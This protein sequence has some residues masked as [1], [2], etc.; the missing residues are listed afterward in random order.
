MSQIEQTH[1]FP[2]LYTLTG[3]KMIRFWSVKACLDKDGTVYIYKEYGKF[4]GKAIPNKKIINDTKSQT[5]LFQQAIFEAESSWKEMQD[6]KGYVADKKLLT[7]TKTQ[8]MGNVTTPTESSIKESTGKIPLTI[9]TPSQA[10]SLNVPKIGPKIS[11][12]LKPESP[13]LPQKL[14]IDS[15]ANIET[16][17]TISSNYDNEIYK[18]F[19]FLPMLANKFIE[20]KGYVSYP[21]WGQPKLDGVRY[22]ARKISPTEVIL[23]TRNDGTCPFFFEIKKDLSQL[24]LDA[25]VLLDGEFY[26]VKIPFKTLNGYCNRKKMD[27]KTGYSKIPK[28]HLESIHYYIFD[29][30]FID[31]PTKPYIERYNY[32]RELLAQNKS[33]YLKL[34]NN[35]LI[36][37]EKEIKNL[38][39]IYV[40]EGN[41]GL[42]IRNMNS[43]YKLKDRS[44]DLLKYKEFEDKEFPIVGA[45]CSTNGKEEGCIIW[46][47]GLP[48]SSTTFTCRPRDTHE[49]RRNDW[50]DYTNNP[51]HFIGQLYTVRFQETYDNGVPRFPVGIAIRYDL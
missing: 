13:S 21:C 41:E 5:D 32:L 22:T 31:Q 36:T 47:L 39:D 34:V 14:E 11:I 49:S 6:K 30:Y 44:N 3:T 15:H 37:E 29:C 4:G 46:I 33:N 27:G 48:D 51:D 25:G 42:M 16:K 38:H 7:D 8:L 12:K 1:I 43:Q 19:K 26:S 10:A 9:K 50:I 28:D 23:R 35:S 24:N 17:K 45:E 2:T 20:R 18:S 40:S